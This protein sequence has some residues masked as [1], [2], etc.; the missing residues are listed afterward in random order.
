MPRRRRYFLTAAIYFVTAGT[1][2]VSAAPYSDRTGAVTSS[3]AASPDELYRSG[4]RHERGHG[5]VQDHRLALEHYCAAAKA[6]HAEAAFSTGWMYL[7]GTGVPVDRRVAAAWFG[8]AAAKGHAS[9]GRM[10]QR[11]PTVPATL[12][13]CD[14]GELARAEH[15]PPEKLVRMIDRLA[16]EHGLDPTLV[17]AVV[18]IESGFR[19]DA[20]SPRSARGLMQLMPDTATRFGVENPFDPA[21]NLRGGIR[22]LQWLLRRF[23]GDVALTLAAYNAGEGAVQRHKG[24]PPYAETQAYIEKIRRYY[25]R[26][27]HPVPH[28]AADVRVRTAKA[29]APAVPNGSQ[30]AASPD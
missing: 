17:L 16:G 13:T 4:R 30:M 10:V 14:G 20:V 9:A 8:K 5:A 23:D 27:R 15:A 29:A 25:P 18:A 26:D 6:G 1:T 12:A 22:Y 7:T 11:L 19:V 21:Q 24:V 28:T 2:A 3:A